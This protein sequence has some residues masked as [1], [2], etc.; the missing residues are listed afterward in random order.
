[1]TEK[2]EQDLAP[3]VAAMKRSVEAIYNRP[4]LLVGTI[5][6]ARADIVDRAIYIFRLD[7][8]GTFYCWKLHASS[9]GAVDSLV[10]ASEPPQPAG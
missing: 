1:M 4:A 8:L 10:I 7:E 5:D 9:A 2:P 3:A 6:S